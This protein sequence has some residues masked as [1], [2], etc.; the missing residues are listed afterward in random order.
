VREPEM[1]A[2]VVEIVLAD[3]DIA[4]AAGP[5]STHRAWAGERAR[6]RPCW[7]TIASRS[8]RGASDLADVIS[9]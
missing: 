9:S 8:C 5:A 1:A 4:S 6:R 3:D 7:W 2:G